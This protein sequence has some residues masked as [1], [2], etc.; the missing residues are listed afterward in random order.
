VAVVF[1]TETAN[2]DLS[3][4]IAEYQLPQETNKR[5]RERLRP[6]ARFPSM[7]SPLEGRWEGSRFLLGPWRWMLVV[8]EYVEEL[9]AV[10]VTTIQDSRR[11]D[12]AT[13]SESA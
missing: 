3:E 10:F 13:S 6:L 5:V 9:D 12:S 11:A 7:G 8:Y 1:V 2:Q 4:L